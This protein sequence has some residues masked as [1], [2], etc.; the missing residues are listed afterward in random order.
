MEPGLAHIIK[1]LHIT[2]H[3]YLQQTHTNPVGRANLVFFVYMYGGLADMQPVTS[4]VRCIMAEFYDSRRVLSVSSM[5]VSINMITIPAPTCLNA[6]PSS[7]SM[8]ACSNLNMGE[9]T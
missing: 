8:H 4:L 1:F 7:G 9:I 6:I 2:M 5:V 3:I